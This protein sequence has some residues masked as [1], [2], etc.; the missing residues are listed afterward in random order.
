ML[1]KDERACVDV[2]EGVYVGR[3]K[4]TNISSYNHQI[5][6]YLTND[7]HYYTAS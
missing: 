1:R 7:M 2:G 3:S 4:Q 6:H 5:A